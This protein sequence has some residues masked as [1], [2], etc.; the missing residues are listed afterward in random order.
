[1]MSTSPSWHV[2]ADTADFVRSL[3]ARARAIPQRLAFIGLLAAVAAPSLA[4]EAPVAFS[5]SGGEAWTFRKSIQITVKGH[6]DRVAITTPRAT[7]V[8]RPRRQHVQAQLPLASGGNE[9]KAE[10][11]RRGVTI[12]PPAFQN[13]QVR[14]R[15]V[16][17]AWITVSLQSGG[18]ALDAVRSEQAPARSRPLVS[19]EWRQGADNPAPLSGL[20]QHGKRITL[21]SPTSDGEYHVTLRVT[22]SDGR[23]DEST[24]AFRV[25]GGSPHI[26]DLEREHSAWIDRAVIYG[27]VPH[28]FGPRGLVDVTAQ[29]DRLAALGVNTLWLSPITASPPGDF[30]YAVT[31]YFQL[32]PGIGSEDDLRELVRSA[33]ERGLKVIA[34]FVP[35]HLSEQHPYFADYQSHR[36][37]SPYA[38]Y[39]A[40]TAKGAVASYFDWDN[41]KNLNFHNPE[42]RRLEIEAFAY[43]IREFD[44]DGFR[45]DAAWG[46]KQR[47]PD[48]WPH[49]RRELKRIKPD[50]LLLAEASARDPYYG[51]HGFDVAYDWTDKLGQW[52]WHDAF[53]DE[54][55]TAKRLRSAIER[56]RSPALVF[57]FLNNNDTGPRFITRYGLARTRVAAAMLLTLP[58]IPGLYM[59]DE[60]GT[61]YEPYATSAPLTW[62]SNPELESWYRRLISTRQAH[63]ALRSREIRWLHV[64]ASDHILA[65]LRPGASAE[66]DIVVLLNYGSSPVSF[67]IPDEALRSGPAFGFTDLLE[68]REIRADGGRPMISLNGYGVSILKRR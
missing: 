46:P 39:F 2:T 41:L 60:T 53:E 5:T 49:W 9:V 15:D 47:A 66:E 34:D 14:L 23:S 12:G 28:F 25:Q 63:S 65:Y 67:A 48:F 18:I 62:G 40:H 32:R 50:L 59:G 8:E 44:I 10:C 27:V 54:S 55:A 35:N 58:G 52:A 68:E 4:A 31:D 21:S 17:K 26:I 45:A 13:W 3:F 29:L 30:G 42:V 43:W 61:A 19:Y 16:P 37:A 51:R 57:R 6:C 33:H 7:I 64:P 22:D 24:A 20:P 11:R 1:M 56:S 36:R 38:T